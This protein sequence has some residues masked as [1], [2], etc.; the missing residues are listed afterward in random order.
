MPRQF[1]VY[2]FIDL[3]FSQITIPAV[4]L[5]GMYVLCQR[6]G[7]SNM[8]VASSDILAWRRHRRFD[9]KV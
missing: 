6:S 5:G 4:D 9:D 1:S 7:Y 3:D 2:E 8:S